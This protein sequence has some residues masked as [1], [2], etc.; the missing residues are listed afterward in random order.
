MSHLHDKFVSR[1]TN[2]E[3]DSRPPIRDDG[4]GPHR[5]TES[6]SGGSEVLTEIV[7]PVD[8]HY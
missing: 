1:L 2:R 6:L 5:V 3:A 4:A 8:S 7:Y